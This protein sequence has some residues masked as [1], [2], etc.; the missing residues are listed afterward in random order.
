MRI[1]LFTPNFLPAVGGT[2]TVTAALASQFHDKGHFVAVLALGKARELGLPYKVSWYR[3]PFI[4]R[5][6]PERIGAA[7]KSLHADHRFDIFVANYGAP[8]GYAAI[9]LGRREGVPTV[10]ISHGG[11]LY[12]TSRDR[13]RRHL[14]KRTLF[15][16]RHANALV[17][18]S[19][20]VETLIRQ[21]N[22]NPVCMAHIPNGVDAIELNRP[23]PRP[24]AFSDQRP[25]CMCLG[26]L[27]PLKGFDDAI[28]AFAAVRSELGNLMLMVVGAGKQETALRQQVHASGL[29][30]D[31]Q[32]MGQRTGADK[33]WFIQNCMFGLMPSI[34]EGHPLV[35]LE[36]LAVGKP[37]ICSTNT[38]FDGIVDNHING[39]RVPPSDPFI[40]GQAMAKIVHLNI[41]DMGKAS[42]R[43]A[44]RYHWSVIADRYLT[45]FATL[46]SNHGDATNS[47]PRL[48]H[49]RSIAIQPQ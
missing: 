35:A 17:A 48:K 37:L 49:Q 9:M 39:L 10:I 14:W 44:T 36:Y 25:F 20:Y 6:F 24:A 33:R 45:L 47:T 8:T 19:P 3:K 2:E 42:R 18:I 26:N 28:K 16:Y 1:C 15:A 31:I 4:S 23:A 46:M 12:Q 34:E 7:L 22:P 21:I 43:R 27:G 11:D 13:K 38:S 5:A 41:A 40:L 32:F 29:D 30:R